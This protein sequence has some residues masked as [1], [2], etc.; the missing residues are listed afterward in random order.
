MAKANNSAN[1]SVGQ[2][3]AGGYVFSAPLT[4]TIP[5]DYSTPLPEEFVNLGYVTEDGIEFSYD[6]DSEDY[7]DLNGDV[8]ESAEG[9]Q[10]EEVIF[11]LAE[12]MSDALKESYGADNVTD[13]D[14]MITVKHNSLPRDE[15]IYAFELLLKNGRKWRSVVP[16]GKATRSGST[17]VAKSDILANQITVKTF[18]DAEGNRLY[19]YIE[20]TETQAGGE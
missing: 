6:G 1:V 13:E 3:V 10:T 2:G 19:D 17:T 11:T 14:G 5:T 4:A 16:R 9:A 15:R 12:I 18:P 7:H 8:Y 20:S